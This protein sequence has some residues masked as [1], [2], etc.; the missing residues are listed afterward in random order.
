MPRRTL[1]LASAKGRLE[2]ASSRSRS[3]AGSACG[4]RPASVQPVANAHRIERQSSR[5]QSQAGSVM[6]GR[7]LSEASTPTA[8]A[9]RG[10]IFGGTAPVPVPIERRRQPA[11]AATPRG[12]VLA[13][14]GGESSTSAP[15]QSPR[16]QAETAKQGCRQVGAEVRPP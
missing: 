7:A 15:Q 5:T 9:K 13:F 10:G 11:A 14:F 2:R 3:L 6:R 16:Q 1:S 4:D 12:G 8:T